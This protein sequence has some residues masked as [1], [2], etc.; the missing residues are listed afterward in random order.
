[1]TA[2]YPIDDL[3]P[4]LA[5]YARSLAGRIQIP[6][7]MAGNAV[8]AVATV[9]AQALA[10]V[11]PP[12]RRAL[13]LSLGFAT[14]AE[15]GDRESTT[16]RTVL[17]ALDLA[18][19]GRELWASDATLAALLRPNRPPS[20]GLF[21]RIWKTQR[22]A[23]AQ[24]YDPRSP[25]AGRR[26]TVYLRLTPLGAPSFLSCAASHGYLIAG[27]ESLAGRRLH[28]PRPSAAAAERQDAFGAL[29][30]GL[31]ARP[32]PLKIG[33]TN[34]LNPPALPL[35]RAACEV[36]DAIKRR[37]YASL[38]ARIAGVL[39]VVENP[40][41]ATVTFSAMTHAANVAAWYAVEAIRLREGEASSA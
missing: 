5:P 14:I 26:V 19:R 30:A 18:G 4:S 20:C 34:T 41:A 38:A 24:R 22:M 6:E 25:P 7:A 37:S 36:W 1:M 12:S 3:G 29:I 10:D 35:T 31:L 8:L 13:P 21:T 40:E 28:W 32:W 16:Q 17:K 9:A 39:T 33:E 11:Q 27:P 23:W 2:P 15:S